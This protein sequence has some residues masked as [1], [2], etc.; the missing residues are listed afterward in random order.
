VKVV[1]TGG[2]ASL[3]DKHTS[4]FDAI[5]PDLTITGLAMMH[6]RLPRT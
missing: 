3:F 6:R 1:T 5:E 4:V 2:L